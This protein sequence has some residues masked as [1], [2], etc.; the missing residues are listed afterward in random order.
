MIG[1]SKKG[2]MTFFI[3]L[4]VMLLFSIGMLIAFKGI[5][6]GYGNFRPYTEEVPVEMQPL[7]LFVQQCIYDTAKQGLILL[8]AQGGYIDPI[9]EGITI[10][11]SDPTSYEGVEFMPG[12]YVP[13]WYHMTSK[14]NC[15]GQCAFSQ[16]YTPSNK[17]IEEQLNKYIAENL[18][19]CT[20]QFS[21][22]PKFTITDSAPTVESNIGTSNMHFNV[23]YPLTVNTGSRTVEI[24]KFYMPVD[25]NLNKMLDDARGIASTELEQHFLE[26]ND[27]E[28]VSL[29]SDIDANLLPP[30]YMSDTEMS[31]VIWVEYDVKKKFERLLQEKYGMLQ[32]QSSDN[33][34]RF[35][36]EESEY[37]P[38]IQK[39]YD[40][41]MIPFSGLGGLKVN[42]HYF[43]S[44][45]IFLK[46]NGGSGAVTPETLMP[47]FIPF[48]TF[49]LQRYMT[50]YDFS[51]PVVV[52]LDDDSAFKEEG[53][54]FR[55]ALEANVRGS[56][57]LLFEN[58]PIYAVPA[59]G[60]MMCN[61]N[62]YNTGDI[63]IKTVDFTTRQPVNDAKIL[64]DAGESCMIGS[65]DM[66]GELTAKYPVGIGSLIVMKQG[67]L[68]FAKAMTT[69][70][71]ED[72]DVGIVWLKAVVKKP[73]KAEIFE[74]NKFGNQWILSSIPKNME[75]EH[76]MIVT[77]ERI[78][79]NAAEPDFKR[80]VM[81]T[82]DDMIQDIE[83]APG[84]YNVQTM[85]MY[86]G[87][88]T[89]PPD[90]RCFKIEE[91]FD[92][93]TV[94]FNIPEK[95]V[96]MPVPPVQYSNVI[97]ITN[98]D[99]LKR[100]PLFVYGLFVNYPG[101]QK[102]LMEDLQVIDGIAERADVK[103]RLKPTK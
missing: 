97:S 61:I 8:G 10:V 103:S 81:I 30:F 101:A 84:D 31:N 98:A 90:T 69:T 75:K 33:A 47:S 72:Q 35:A 100:T 64:F 94:C 88:A 54:T 9:G 48:I 40:F 73:V 11:N 86:E 91:L 102:V 80:V 7:Q 2:Q 85:L 29:Y 96:T 3:A 37:A 15:A 65:T 79:T 19:Y 95:A 56:E 71:D 78:K 67:Y 26:Y 36:A 17:K 93:E 50:V 87:N 74:L 41:M 23:L 42:F 68:P 82:S 25:L 32:A 22:F 57:P 53:Y 58:N 45:P 1:L 4:G 59:E 20:R 66:N 70:L 38:T 77:F 43:D 62:Q 89:I 28:L 46:L 51:H 55:F 12:V 21:E 24:S 27:L 14:N 92:D 99:L 13:Y 6:S 39:F 52:E 44:W 76:S 34:V 63:H 83:L 18:Q 60:S 49:G 16:K 5:G